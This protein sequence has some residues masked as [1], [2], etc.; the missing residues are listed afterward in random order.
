MLKKDIAFVLSMAAKYP[1]FVVPSWYW[2]PH[3]MSFKDFESKRAQLS[4]DRGYYEGMGVINGSSYHFQ[5]PLPRYTDTTALPTIKLT[6]KTKG[7]E[8]AY[9]AYEMDEHELFN[10]LEQFIKSKSM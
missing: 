5:I 10:T 6:F 7:M 9:E 2:R 8:D 4:Q 1:S 3:G